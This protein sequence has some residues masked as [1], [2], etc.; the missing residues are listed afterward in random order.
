[1]SL[2]FLNDIPSHC[3]TNTTHDIAELFL[4]VAFEH[5]CEIFQIYRGGQFYWGRKS[6]YPAK[7]IALSKVIDRHDHTML[8]QVHLTMSGIRASHNHCIGQG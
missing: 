3:T 8:Y 5:Y 7:K 2:I 1:M 6:E 4:K